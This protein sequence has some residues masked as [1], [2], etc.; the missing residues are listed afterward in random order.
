MAHL[1]TIRSGED[2]RDKANHPKLAAQETGYQETLCETVKSCL[3][4]GAFPHGSGSPGS[5]EPNNSRDVQGAMS[6]FLMANLTRPTKLPT[7]KSFI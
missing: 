6:L 1:W 7:D 2:A 4:E 3:K 5:D